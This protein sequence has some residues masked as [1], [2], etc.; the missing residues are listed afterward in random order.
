M[1]KPSSKKQVISKTIKPKKDKEFYVKPAEFHNAIVA[2]YDQKNEDIPHILGDMIQKIATKI[3]FLSN[4]IKYSYKEEMI[5]DAVVRMISAL[6]R[7]KY[8]IEKGNPFSYF[9]KIAIH[10]FIS[11][12]KKEKQ[13]QM[14]LKE[15]QEEQYMNL[16]T[17]GE[18]W[19]KT[20]AHRA[21][22]MDE[23]DFYYDAN[24]DDFYNEDAKIPED[25]NEIV[26]KIAAEDEI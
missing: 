5:G 25:E 17:S 22:D 12:I 8:A 20:R 4:F 9:T 11:R 7:K 24:I 6:K 26:L 14:T 19:L 18:A 21:D 16:T 1:K 23:N 3:S 13:N 10:A 15:Y 2:Y